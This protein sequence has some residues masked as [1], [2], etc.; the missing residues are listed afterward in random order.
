MESVSELEQSSEGGAR[1]NTA[2]RAI[3]RSAIEAVYSNSLSINRPSDLGARCRIGTMFLNFRCLK[4]YENSV[5]R[6]VV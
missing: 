2:C 5:M 3:R 1:K 6:L 4:A